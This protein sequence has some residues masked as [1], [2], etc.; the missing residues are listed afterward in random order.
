MRKKKDIKKSFICPYS[1]KELKNS[2][3]VDSCN[4]NMDSTPISKTYKRCFLNYLEALRY[5]PYKSKND[6]EDEY[7]SIPFNQRAQIVGSFFNL[8]EKEVLKATSN[9]Y[10]SMFSV[11]AQDSILFHH[12]HHLD[13][14]P[15]RQCAVCGNPSDNLFIP[16]HGGLPQGWGYCSY[17]CLQK[18]CVPLLIL[19]KTL[20]LDT[21]DLMT[22]LEYENT[23]S[24][25]KFVRNLINWIFS[26]TPMT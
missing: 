2:C 13:P 17:A 10:I 9:F 8:D 12:K 23:Q 11:I 5:N 24:R 25:A 6:R 21:I 1:N 14:V 3:D 4:F 15:Y 26:N 19:E 20:D 7:S 22:S 16:K 18:K